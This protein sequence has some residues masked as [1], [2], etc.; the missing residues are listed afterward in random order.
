M[1]TIYETLEFKNANGKYFN[2]YE[3][4]DNLPVTAPFT[5]LSPTEGL[6]NP[7]FDWNKGEYIGFRADGRTG[8][9]RHMG[10]VTGMNVQFREIF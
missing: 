5:W 3:V 2:E 7:K 8:S 1:R 9:G 6:L 10:N 4:P